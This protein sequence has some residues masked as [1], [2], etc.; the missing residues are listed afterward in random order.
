DGAC[1]LEGV[2]ET[3]WSFA[4]FTM[5]WKLT[6]PGHPVRFER[7][8]PFCV[9][10]P[11]RIGDLETFRPVVREMSSDAEASEEF[12]VFADNRQQMQLR[13]FASPYVPEL[14]SYKTDWERH[15]YTGLTP[16]GKSAPRH[17]VK[18][19]LARFEREEN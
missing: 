14:E 12:A 5:N 3:D 17:V 16:S 11:Q 19:Q 2:V 4:N 15:Y 10:L 9:I 7:D 1:A 6:R 8:D 18:R 13:K